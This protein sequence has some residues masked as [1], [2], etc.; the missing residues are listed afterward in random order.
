MKSERKATFAKSWVKAYLPL[1]FTVFMVWFFSFHYFYGFYHFV[2]PSR[3]FSSPTWEH[4]AQKLPRCW[5]YPCLSAA[6]QKIVKLSSKAMREAAASGSHGNNNFYRLEAEISEGNNPN[7][8][9]QVGE[10]GPNGTGLSFKAKCYCR[11]AW[12][13]LYHPLKGHNNDSHI[14]ARGNKAKQEFCLHKM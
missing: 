3:Y 9:S 2:C 7:C 10:G 12:T 13:W 4:P 8:R 14:P 6:G 11:R 5:M 1:L